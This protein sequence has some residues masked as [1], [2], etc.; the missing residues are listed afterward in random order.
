VLS[1]D[2][3]NVK[4][5]L[6]RKMEV[7]VRKPEHELDLK[8]EP[9]TQFILHLH[10]V[11]SETLSARTG[12][13]LVLRRATGWGKQNLIGGKFDLRH[14]TGTVSP[15]IFR[16]RSVPLQKRQVKTYKQFFLGDL[17]PATGFLQRSAACHHRNSG[18]Q[19][20]KFLFLW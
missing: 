10:E 13:K 9:P 15:P 4:G 19:R 18:E 6:T 14:A 2:K 8:D 11:K 1:I 17:R 3:T 5:T 16:L 7:Q 20:I 12:E